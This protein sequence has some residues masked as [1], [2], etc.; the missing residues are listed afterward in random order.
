[1]A[2][3]KLGNAAFGPAHGLNGGSPLPF[4]AGAALIGA[5]ALAIAILAARTS[6]RR[7]IT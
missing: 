2:G 5:F 1:M 6:L 3:I 4:V 7:D